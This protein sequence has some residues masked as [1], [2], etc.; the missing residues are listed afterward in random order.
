MSSNFFLHMSFD[1][2]KR[3][4]IINK[5]QTFYKPLK[6]FFLYTLVWQNIFA[7]YFSFIIFLYAEVFFIID[8]QSCIIVF[9]VYLFLSSYLLSV[10]NQL[11]NT[12]KYGQN[13]RKPVFSQNLQILLFC[14]V[15]F[16]M[17]SKI[18]KP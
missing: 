2:S 7:F 3:I 18:E 13:K 4:A 8:F 17:K 5:I 6:K 10:S 14:L 9:Q 15:H 1:F 11:I 12:S 16:G